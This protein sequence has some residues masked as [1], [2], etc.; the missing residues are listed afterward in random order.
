MVANGPEA[1]DDICIAWDWEEVVA[2]NAISNC[3]SREAAFRHPAALAPVGLRST[4]GHMSLKCRCKVY[5]HSTDIQS[6]YAIAM[7]IQ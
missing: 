6:T 2:D 1:E 7:S 3:P 4:V 5:T